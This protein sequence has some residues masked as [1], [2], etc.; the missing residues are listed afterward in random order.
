MS[1]RLALA[2]ALGSA[3]AACNAQATTLSGDLTADNAF[4]AFVS[5]NPAVLGTP[6]ANSG[7]GTWTST[8][9]FST[10]L[11]PG[12]IYYL[13]IE[14]INEG[15]SGMFVGDFTL[16]NTDFEFSNGSQYLL[17][18][19][20]H[21]SGVFNNTNSAFAPQPWVQPT[22]GVQYYD[23]NGHVPA[24][25]PWGPRGGIDLSA[26]FIWPN[27]GQSNDGCFNL[28]GFCTVDLMTE[29]LPL[30]SA[31]PLPATLPLLATG[32]G[33]IGFI[34]KRRKRK[35]SIATA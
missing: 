4:F 25:N 28:G 30:T 8:F 11:A 24:T 22:G 15:S 18:D 27:D 16:S 3:L 21:W 20:T 10:S 9:N 2:L 29:I 6:V 34:A 19:T 7:G 5:T 31:T 33:V 26:L 14:A 32:L 23:A 17:T 12:Q 1:S 13:Q 35:H